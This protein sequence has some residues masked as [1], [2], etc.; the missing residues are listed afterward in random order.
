MFKFLSRKKKQQSNNEIKISSVC[1]EYWIANNKVQLVYLLPEEDK[2]RLYTTNKGYVIS[3]FEEV[4]VG[5][6]YTL[7]KENCPIE[8][9]RIISSNKQYKDGTWIDISISHDLLTIAQ[10]I[11][12][13]LTGQRH[14]I[15]SLDRV[16][17]CNNQH[18]I[19]GM[20]IELVEESNRVLMD[21][22]ADC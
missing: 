15:T 5:D 9:N 11:G 10:T 3:P 4:D 21:M 13:F 20:P 12:K 18:K 14:L 1:A 19:Y 8:T 7:L 16:A 2:F 22:K 6:V 17:I